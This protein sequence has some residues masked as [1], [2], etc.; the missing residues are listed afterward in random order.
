MMHDGEEI[1]C[2]THVGMNRCWVGGEYRYH[3]LPHA[4][5]DEPAYGFRMSDVKQSAP[6]TWG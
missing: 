6:R 3:S 5:G 1:V 2:P 4:R